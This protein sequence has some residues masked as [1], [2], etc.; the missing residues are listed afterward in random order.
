MPNFCPQCGAKVLPDNVFC[1]QCGTRL[2]PLPNQ[3]QPANYAAQP[4]APAMNYAAQPTAN[5][6]SQPAAPMQNNA[7]LAGIPA[8]GY[9]NRV[10][11]PEILAAMKKNRKAGFVFSC[12]VIPLPLV[13]F[14]IYALASGKMEV[15]EAVRNGA[16]VSCVFL[17][18]AVISAICQKAKKSYDAVVTNQKTE[19]VYR[20][21][22]DEGR[23]RVTEYYTYV[24]LTDGKTKKIVE[25]EGSMILAYNY[26][27]VGDRFRYH[28]QFH[29][30]Y[31]LY[32]KS[33]ASC[34]Y[35]V[36]CMTKNPVTGDR[37]TKCHL[38]L[39]K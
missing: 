20:H 11:D 37:C 16:I 5:Y 13:G 12:F 35:C 3:A 14:V 10:N 29:F 23:E 17:V 26:L 28:P 32:D 2:A 1:V 39:L 7:A 27:N 34:I 9:S 4:A 15:G 18:M 6:V 19:M 21:K 30:P 24:K 22:N 33:K 8:P 25:R 38:P 36:S 31:E